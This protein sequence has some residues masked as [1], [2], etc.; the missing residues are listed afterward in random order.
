[1]LPILIDPFSNLRS[2]QNLIYQTPLALKS[3]QSQT[4][5]L[6]VIQAFPGVSLCAI[7]KFTNAARVLLIWYSS[8]HVWHL[9]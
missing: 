4:P 8:G 1:M 9:S 7:A 5:E 6:F 2:N 3:P